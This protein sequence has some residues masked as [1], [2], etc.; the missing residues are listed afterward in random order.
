MTDLAESQPL[1]T[2]KRRDWRWASLGAAQG[3]VIA[4]LLVACVAA[5]DYVTGY[6]L[7]LAILYLLP[8][9]L[10]TWTGGPR[11][12]MLIVAAASLCW[13]VT[14]RSTHAYSQE[15]FF[16]WEGLVMFAA[17]ITRPSQ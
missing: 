4:L 7:R 15:I 6:E 5:L 8:I 13:L 10:S 16:Y 9:A 11:S 12:G 17:Y 1:P 2:M 3:F 14:F